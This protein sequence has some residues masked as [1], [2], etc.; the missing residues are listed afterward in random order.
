MFCSIPVG[1]EAQ[2]IITILF[3]LVPASL[4]VMGLMEGRTGQYA[5]LAGLA[6]HLLTMVM[7]GITV[8][9]VPLTE[10]FDAISFMSF[11]LALTYWYFSKRRGVRDLGLLAL[12]LISLI[13]IIA[14]AYTPINTVSPFQRTPW[15]YL[16][17]FFYVVSYGYFG[18]SA[19][20]GVLYLFT[21]KG[22]Y[23]PLQYQG[24]IQ[25][26]IMLSLALVAGSVWFFTAYG[27]YWLWTSKELWATLTWFY[28]GLYLHARYLRGLSGRPSAIIGIIGFFVALF[29]YFGVGTIIPAP[30]T[31]F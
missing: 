5:F 20:V 27:T 15:F 19:C 11:A 30:P 28:Y 26:W 16:H 23:E 8:G 3:I 10:K 1:E 9:T 14:A 17:M 2:A 7:R 13:L 31:Q 29:T 12:P 4:Y 6:S 18:I 25:G 24:A 22:E 21:K